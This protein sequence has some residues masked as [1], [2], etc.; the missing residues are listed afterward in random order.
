MVFYLIFGN[1]FYSEKEG[2]LIITTD[3]TTFELFSNVHIITL[4]VCALNILFL[5][6]Y[7]NHP[8]FKRKNIR[9]FERIFAVSLFL[10]E[11]IYHILF[12]LNGNWRIYDSL[13]LELSSISLFA[14]I[15]LLWTGNRRLYVFVFFAG[16]GGALQALITP[17][18]S[19]NFPHFRFFHFFYT[20]IGVIIAALYFTWA[21]GYRPVF[22]DIWKAMMMLNIVAA[23]VFV[24]NLFTKGNY[25]FLNKKPETASVLDF[26]GPYPY[27]IISLEVFAL[28]FSIGLW[29]IFREK[30]SRRNYFT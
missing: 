4:F 16:I 2:M 30:T 25:M 5:Y 17:V 18:L 19:Y 28:L 11:L 27:Y 29:L 13:P 21:K 6:L 15:L 23:F 26:L 22:K 10:T 24:A 7:R 20:H 3:N 12:Y 9:L 1:R 14:T 8:F